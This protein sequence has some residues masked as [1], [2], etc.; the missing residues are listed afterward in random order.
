M[1]SAPALGAE[2][3]AVPAKGRPGFIVAPM[4]LLPLPDAPLQ[5]GA[6]LRRGL[7]VP[8]TRGTSRNRCAPAIGLSSAR[9]AHH[10]LAGAGLPAGGSTA[11]AVRSSGRAPPVPPRRGELLLP[12]GWPR[13]ETR[14]R[15]TRR[16]HS[17]RST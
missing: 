7:S 15:S 5:C 6:A 13:Q 8:H 1:S 12:R 16:T 3:S 17:R 4:Y 9:F 2:D 14:R 11:P 10:H